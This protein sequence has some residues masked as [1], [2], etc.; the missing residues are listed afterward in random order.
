MSAIQT[1]V[2]PELP[3]ARDALEPSISAE[4]IDY[5]YG[6]HHQTYVNNLNNLLPNGGAPLEELIKTAEGGIFNNAAQIWNHTF[7]WNCMCH[8]GSPL[9]DGALKSA[10]EAKWGS[11]DAFI[12]E[13]RSK[14]VS[15]FGSGWSW[16]VKKADGSLDI[17]CTTNA[18]NP[19]RD[20]M[21]P[22][23][24][25]DVWEHAYY[26]DYRNARASYF[27]KWL[28]VVNWKFVSENF[29]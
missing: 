7:Y 22:L 1:Y 25:C 4:T 16:L 21:K 15:F 17:I 20:G 10:I 24:C 5:H 23:L 28:E 8:G 12:E 6:K 2:L 14:T 29:A 9:E 19:I 18:G 27:N 26:I 3:Y 11:Y 13:L